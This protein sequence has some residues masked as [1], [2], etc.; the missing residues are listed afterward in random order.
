MWVFRFLT[1][2][3]KKAL[4]FL[5]LSI[6]TISKKIEPLWSLNP[7]FLPAWLKAW[8]GK[9]ATNMSWVG[10]SSELIFW[11]SPKA[12]SPKFAR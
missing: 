6:L 8:Q 7:S 10:I 3:S 12:S 1:F 5:S 9:P 2:S 11:I 4:G